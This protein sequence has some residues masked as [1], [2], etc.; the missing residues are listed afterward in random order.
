MSIDHEYNDGYYRYPELKEIFFLF[1]DDIRD[2]V[3]LNPFMAACRTLIICVPIKIALAM[4]RH[5]FLL[6]LVLDGVVHRGVHDRGHRVSILRTTGI[7]A[8]A[9]SRGTV[10]FDV[11]FVARSIAF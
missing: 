5:H 1:T 10:V 6:H 11:H 9:A 7:T 3:F 4:F 8:D 2:I